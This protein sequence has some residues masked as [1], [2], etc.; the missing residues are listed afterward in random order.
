MN[1]LS[2]Q[3]LKG[4]ELQ[5]L[6]GQGGFG[7]VYRAYQTLVKREVAV[8]IILPVYANNPDFVRSFEAEAQLIARLE[9][10]HIVPLYDYWREPNG[11]YLVMRWLRGGSLQSN[12]RQN[13]PFTV[14]GAARLLDQMAAALTIAHRNNVIHRDIKPGNILL[15]QE[16]NAYL[17]DFGIAK[18]LDTSNTGDEEG[19]MVGSPAYMSPEQIRGESITPQTDIYSLG[20]VMYEILTGEQP[21][22]PNLT[23]S[24]LI[25]KHLGEPLPELRKFRSDLPA[26]LD[27]VIEQA[28]AKRPEE[29]FADVLAFA[30]EFRHAVNLTSMF[31]GAA[32][33]DVVTTDSGSPLFTIKGSTSGIISINADTLGLAIE[34]EN[35][36][37]GLRA[38]Q[39]ADAADFFGRDKLI[40]RLLG[41]LTERHEMSRFLAVIGPSGSGK[42][43]VV[44][45]GVLP[46]LR[47][48]ALPGSERWFYVEMVPGIHPVGKLAQALLSVAIDP[49][50]GL[51]RQLREN[52]RG[53][54][55]AVNRILPDNESEL[56]LVIDQFEE[57]FTQAEDE[58]ERDHF[59]KILLVAASDPESRLRVIITLRADF[60]DRPLLFPEFGNLIRERTEVVLP[61]SAADLEEAIVGP[62]QRV[63]MSVEEKLIAAVV[64]DVSGEIGALPLLQYALTEVFERRRGRNL[65]LEAYQESGGAL[66]ALARRAT[67]LYSEMD[68]KHQ[69][70][71]RQLFLRMVT[72]GEGTEDTRRRVRWAELFSIAANEERMQSV[73]DSFTRYRLLTTDNDP[74]TRE[75]TIT[76][77][78]EAL[79]RK[80]EHL[81][82]WLDESRESLLL[83]RRLSQSTEEWLSSKQDKSFLASGV[84]LTQFEQLVA[85]GDI[86]LSQDE[87]DF[88]TASVTEREARAAEERARKAEE[89]E[90]KRRTRNR[91][92]AAAVAAGVA[93]M[94]I[95]LTAIALYQRA[96][97]QEARAEAEDNAATA[98]I[99]QGQAIFQAATATIAQG[100]AEFSAA[101]ATIA[102]GQ[103]EINEQQ[104]NSLSL[105][106]YSQQAQQNNDINLALA[107]A[108]AAAAIPNPPPIAQGALFEAAIAPNQRYI[109]DPDTVAEAHQD[110]LLAA[111]ISPDGL[112][113]LSSGG[114]PFGEPTDTGIRLWD[115]QT[116]QVIHILEGHTAGVWAIT[117]SPDGT[118][119]LSGDIGG[120]IILWNLEDGTEIKRF[121]AR[122]D[123]VLG[124]AFTPDGKQ[125]VAGGSDNLNQAELDPDAAELSLWDIETGEVVRNF[126][127]HQK[128][129]WEVAISPDG[130]TLLSGSAD[131][132]GIGGTLDNS[133]RWWDIETGEEQ[134]R[135]TNELTGFPSVAFVSDAQAVAGQ[136]GSDPALVLINL[137]TGRGERFAN[138]HTDVV[139]DIAVSANGQYALSGGGDNQVVLWDIATHQPIRTFIGHSSAVLGVDITADGRS[140]FTVSIDMTARVWDLMGGVEVRQFAPAES[141]I[142]AMQLSQDGQ[143]ALS[144]S[145]DGRVILWDVVTGD[146]LRQLEGQTTEIRSVAISPNGTLAAAGAINDAALQSDTVAIIVWNLA[147]GEVVHRLEGHTREVNALAFSSDGQSLFSGGGDSDTTK[148]VRRWDMTTGAE[149]TTY[150][151]QTEIIWS[152]ALSPDGQTLAVGNSLGIIAFYNA[153]SAEAQG[154]PLEGHT[155]LVS[156]LTFNSDGRQLLSGGADSILILWEIASGTKLA[157]F[158][159][160][161]GNIN[162]GV[163]SNDGRWVLSAADDNTIRLWD[164]SNGQQIRQYNGHTAGVVGAYFLGDAS[165]FISASA[166]KTL[167]I[168]QTL[169]DLAQL[170]T[171]V[172][173]NRAITPLLPEEARRYGLSSDEP[174]PTETITPEPSENE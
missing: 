34:P 141:S 157:T 42:S 126:E 146:M 88:V 10:L 78:H 62:A 67:D 112:R 19:I 3:T 106:Y 76:V 28:T 14:E 154:S 81:R 47:K 52:E 150:G 160:H 68:A 123:W 27:M 99:A 153:E 8:K 116:G 93:L 90:L 51:P 73:M 118:Q 31:G 12:L 59:L 40:E 142:S 171:W 147:T 149:T 70:T 2:G 136:G 24:E 137:T 85:E 29:R 53:L 18:N 96:E 72:L 165:T 92:I 82:V 139:W 77:A 54:V 25:F 6:I 16:G 156:T 161:T 37:K 102:Q 91:S 94:G 143:I 17:T 166:D 48:G 158:P 66:G 98:T 132:F 152:I 80:W 117:F 38:F 4:Y 113:A 120:T 49:P 41:R 50:A 57:V 22:G 58:Y 63:G 33:T 97:A 128:G 163:L 125:F 15:D 56:V 60:Y 86:A 26:G 131:L 45:A 159:D 84:R 105:A 21:Y 61:L 172:A 155:N 174:I 35:P 140:G 43:S 133:V 32:D 36:Y 89:L 83:Q 115:L 5:E 100:Q 11:A 20:V 170:Q 173:E 101:T 23:S 169:G 13:G 129:I 119:A 114:N 130:K 95:F 164:A 127:G 167:R 151:D 109:F 103:A 145:T 144:G 64:G 124:L 79:I 69:E 55:Q 71:V 44:K 162:T 87:R 107:L 46:A 7:A 75:P 9:N 74:M 135:Y 111:D 30:K 122:L 121:D 104:A 134:G 110:L 39:E 148:R 168:W 138:A 1:N 65:T 108:S